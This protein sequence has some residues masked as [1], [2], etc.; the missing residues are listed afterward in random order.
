L[1]RSEDQLQQSTLLDDRHSLVY[2]TENGMLLVPTKIGAK[3]YKIETHWY[4]LSVAKY[5]HPE[6]IGMSSS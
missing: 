6:Q 4:F 2:T 1:G 3:G 5:L